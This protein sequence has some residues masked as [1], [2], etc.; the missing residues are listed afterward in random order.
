M[1]ICCRQMLLCLK[2]K[3]TQRQMSRHNID[4]SMIFLKQMSRHDT[5]FRYCISVF[6]GDCLIFRCEYKFPCFKKTIW[7]RRSVKVAEVP[8]DV[9]A[10]ALQYKIRVNTNNTRIIYSNIVL[11]MH[12]TTRHLE[13]SHTNI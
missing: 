11:I 4:I 8:E 5:T 6:G 1:F 13:T 9:S 3:F 7:H 12:N 10:R 2:S